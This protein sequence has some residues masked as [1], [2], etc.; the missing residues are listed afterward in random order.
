M[1]EQFE[2]QHVAKEDRYVLID[3]ADGARKEIGEE[4][5]VDVANGETQQR[6]MYHT[7][8]SEDYGGQG[9]ASVLVRFAVEHAIG[10]GLT[11][12]PVCPYVVKWLE[13]HGEYAAHLV[14]AGPQH[15]QA[16]SAASR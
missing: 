7:A 9:L 1:A 13:K 14:K 8:V 15:L 2:V 3:T 6:V 12:V 10:E 16:A 4:A 11:V 5:Y